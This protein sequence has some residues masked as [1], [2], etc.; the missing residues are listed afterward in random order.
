M[1]F[2]RIAMLVLLL[3]LGVWTALAADQPVVPSA[4]AAPVDAT[5]SAVTASA[6][7]ARGAII[8][9]TDVISDVT[10]ESIERRVEEALD[11]GAGVI[12]FVLVTPG[13]QVSSALDI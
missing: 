3:P 9:I 11:D 5:E 12:I 6:A 7:H 13:G 1:A 2:A 8:P 4:D 10:T